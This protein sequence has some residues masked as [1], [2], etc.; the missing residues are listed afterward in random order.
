MKV[1]SKT[2]A[3]SGSPDFLKV[4][5]RVLTFN[6]LPLFLIVL[7]VAVPLTC[8]LTAWYLAP[9]KLRDPLASWAH[10]QGYFPAIND[11]G[12][13]KILLLVPLKTIKMGGDQSKVVAANIA[14][15]EVVTGAASKDGSSLTISESTIKNTRFFGRIAY[16]KKP[17]YGSASIDAR[18]IKF[19][20]ANI[21]ARVQKGSYLSLEGKRI[22]T[23]GMDV[24]QLY[25]TVMKPRLKK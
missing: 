24:E 11:G 12:M 21:R 22:K 23:E 8:L 10:R 1:K 18:N 19:E 17:E 13:P 3:T 9:E 14:M 20:E 4:I 7:T 2:H 25:E 15:E 16:I 6:S 5:K